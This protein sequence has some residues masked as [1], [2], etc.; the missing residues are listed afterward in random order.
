MPGVMILE[1][2]AQAGGILLLKAVEEPEKKVVYFMS[3]D[4][5]KFRRPV[6][7]GDQ[8]RFELEMK[9]FRRNTCR[10]Q[11]KGFVGDALVVEAELMAMVVDQ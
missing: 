3:I 9:V 7:P 5:V 2:M 6:K 4:K 10:M 8:L 1:A 11:G